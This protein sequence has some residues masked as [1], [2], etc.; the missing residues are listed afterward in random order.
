MSDGFFISG[1]FHAVSPGAD[2][3]QR[4]IEALLDAEVADKITEDTERTLCIVETSRFCLSPLCETQATAEAMFQ[5][6]NT[7]PHVE[8]ILLH[9][10]D[11]EA[12]IRFT[13]ALSAQLYHFLC[14][15][16]PDIEFQLDAQLFFEQHR[17]EQ[18][19]VVK[20][21]SNSITLLAFRNNKLQ[22]CN[23]I[24]ATGHNNQNY[25]ILSA[26]GQL[27]FDPIEDPLYLESD[28]AELRKTLNTYIKC[29]S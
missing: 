4:T 18:G 26:W 27:G 24:E 20:A 23:R 15:T 2:F 5:L 21:C 10:T 28:D 3:D 25:F 9:S 29:V 22:L 8:E 17:S 11:E 19:M 16:L 7:T 14:R 12:Q 13:Y 1:Q 6:N